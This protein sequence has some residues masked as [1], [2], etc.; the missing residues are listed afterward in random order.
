MSSSNLILSRVKRHQIEM[1]QTRGFV[2]PQ[3]ELELL[4]KSDMEVWIL[5]NGYLKLDCTYVK[6]NNPNLRAGVFYRSKGNSYVQL[7]SVLNIL[8]AIQDGLQEAVVILDANLSPTAKQ[9]LNRMSTCKVQVWPHL[10]LCTNPT[11][12]LYTP[13]HTVLSRDEENKLVRALVKVEGAVPTSEERQLAKQK[14][15]KMLHKDIISRWYG[16][17]V[18]SIVRLTCDFSILRGAETTAIK[19]RVVV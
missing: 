9:A 7:E 5:T 4:D 18:G 14:M 13:L 8:L 12:H 2:I 1:M 11:K 16:F 10:D 6:E 3:A 17:S 15:P 19:Y